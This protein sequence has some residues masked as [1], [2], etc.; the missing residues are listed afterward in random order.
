MMDKVLIA[1]LM[2][3]CGPLSLLAQDSVYITIGDRSE[4]ITSVNN[5]ATRRL[6]DILANGPMSVSLN[7]YGGFEKVG[8]LPMS[9]PTSD[10]P[11][12]TEPGDVILYQGRN[13]VI[14]YGSNTWSYTRLGKI[15]SLS[16]NEIRAFL[17][18]GE[19]EITL[20][21]SPMSG[22]EEI[23]TSHDKADIIY[24]LKGNRIYGRPQVPG[25]YIINGKKTIIKL[26]LS[27]KL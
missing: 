3:M 26:L 24:D 11:I 22:I 10:S 9:L 19:I 6:S 27:A 20:S 25:L 13:L 4:T 12:T 2:F 8:S 17:G 7:D 18:D 5:D 1:S 16:A 14:F 15:K 23:M 21:L